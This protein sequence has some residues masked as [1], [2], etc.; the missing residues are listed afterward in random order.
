MGIESNVCLEESKAQICVV[1]NCADK[2]EENDNEDE[3][4]CCCCNGGMQSIWNSMNLLP[5][6]SSL[7]I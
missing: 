5:L 4:L 3:M 1:P 2:N 6:K 7:F